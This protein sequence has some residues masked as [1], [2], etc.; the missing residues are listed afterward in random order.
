[1]A[2]TP[3][4]EG[5]DGMRVAVQAVAV[6]GVFSWPGALAAPKLFIPEMPLDNAQV[7]VDPVAPMPTQMI[8]IVGALKAQRP[9]KL[10]LI[11]ISEPTRPY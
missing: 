1:M 3:E 4:G 8:G 11:H 5:V 10:S 7:G 9:Q 2:G 6:G